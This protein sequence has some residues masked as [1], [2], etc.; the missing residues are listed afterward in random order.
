[1]LLANWTQASQ[2]D[3]QS[4]FGLDADLFSMPI[5]EYRCG[6]TMLNADL[7]HIVSID[8]AFACSPASIKEHFKDKYVPE[9]FYMD[10]AKG[11]AE[12]RYLAWHNTQLDFPDF[13]FDVA[14]SVYPFFT[15][16]EDARTKSVIEELSE[17]IRVAKVVYLAPHKFDNTQIART[18]GPVM[19]LLQQ[20]N[21]GVAMMPIAPENGLKKA[22][23]LKLWA[24]SCLR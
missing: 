5:L 6:P 2:K 13:H 23:I 24:Q 22:V 3:Y 21:V 12:K 1:M 7:P 15:E 10:Y 20:K 17:L 19:L 8:E 9:L 18:L 11:Y 14:L 4:L 16:D